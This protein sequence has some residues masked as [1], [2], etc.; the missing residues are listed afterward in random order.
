MSDDP[1]Q[2]M[3]RALFRGFHFFIHFAGD[4][5]DFPGLDSLPCY[6]VSVEN[7]N[8]K[9]R[10]DKEMLAKNKRIKTF[11]CPIASDNRTFIVVG[12]GNNKRRI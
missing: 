9:V 11:T 12:G 5:E 7:G 10:A 3:V 1:D 8:V 6:Q 4:I 2:V